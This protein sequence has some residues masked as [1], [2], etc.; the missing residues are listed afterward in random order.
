MIYAQLRE[1]RDSTRNVMSWEEWRHMADQM[2][3][4]EAMGGPAVGH[5]TQS[6]CTWRPGDTVSTIRSSSHEHPGGAAPGPARA[7]RHTTEMSSVAG[8]PKTQGLP[9]HATWGK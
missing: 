6:A 7:P 1:L 9:R 2:G 4:V 8:S 5:R 3:G